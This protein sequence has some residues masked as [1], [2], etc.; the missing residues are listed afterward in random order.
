GT[1]GYVLTG[2]SESGATTCSQAQT[3]SVTVT[4]NPLPTAQLT[5][6]DTAVCLDDT[7][8]PVVTLTGSGGTAPYTFTVTVDGTSQTL[9]SNAAGVSTFTLATG[10]AMDH[11]VTLDSVSDSATP[12]CGQAVG[13]TATVSVIAPPAVP[14]LTDI[15]LCDDNNDGF[16]C[17]NLQAAADQATGGDPDLAVAFFLTAPDAALGSPLNDIDNIANFCNNVPV[18]QTLYVRLWNVNAPDCASVGTLELYVDPRPVALSPIADYELCDND[19]NGTESF[20]LTGYA[21]NI[22]ANP[23]GLTITFYL[24]QADAQSGTSPIASPYVS[25]GE[26]IWV[27]LANTY[28]QTVTSFNLVV[29]PL[30]Q[31][32]EPL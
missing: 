23:A 10:T 12:S 14:V 26:T 28:C 5:V 24:S 15:R 3:G 2:V 30:P 8:L 32:T 17:F 9:V 25:A 16:T 31:L 22:V 21:G 20:D 18:H 6:S 27:N 11:M 1:F 29:N 19:R 7:N 4:V 13:Q